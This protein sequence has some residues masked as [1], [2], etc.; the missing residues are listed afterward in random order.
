M[1][2]FLGAVFY[3][4]KILAIFW[5][6]GYFVAIFQSFKKLKKIMAIWLFCGYFWFLDQFLYFINTET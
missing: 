1:W 3:K 6:G 5:F 2:L 4:K